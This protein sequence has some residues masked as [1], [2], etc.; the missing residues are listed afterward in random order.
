M[1]ADEIPFLRAIFQYPGDDAARL[2]YADWLEERGDKRAELLRLDV[3]RQGK[4]IQ[5]SPLSSSWTHWVCSVRHQHADL[6]HDF[7]H[8]PGGKGLIE[9]EG[10]ARETVLLVEKKPVAFNWDDCAGSVGQY[11]VYTGH[12][13]STNLADQMREFINTGFLDPPRR[14]QGDRAIDATQNLGDRVLP[15]LS[16]FAPG[17]YCIAYTPSHAVD[18]TGS[19]DQD[20]LN[21]ELQNYYPYGRNLIPTQPR[22]RLSAALVSIYGSR[23]RNGLRPIVLTTSAEGAWCEFVI[24]G[25]H[26]LEAYGREKFRPAI[27]CIERWDAPPIS[28]EKGVG[29]L[30]EG[31]PGVV[32]YRRMKAYAHQLQ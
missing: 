22:G 7:V 15:L 21:T 30:P 5:I 2:I 12:D 28:L 10:G 9:V 26:K 31:H 13:C 8:L 17:F 20:V 32:E 29:Y 25:H 19:M 18:D 3:Q 1:H 4:G 23:I 11:L 27:L 6:V 24:D 14:H 16:R